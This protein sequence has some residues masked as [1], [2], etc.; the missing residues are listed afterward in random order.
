MYQRL[1]LAVL[2]G[3]LAFGAASAQEPDRVSAPIS[4]KNPIKRSD[5][6]TNH[7]KLTGVLVSSSN[8]SALVNGRPVQE[9]DHIAGA[10]VLEIEPRGI[11]VLVGARE[12]AINVGSSID[13]D[14]PATHVVRSTGALARQNRRQQRLV[15]GR[16]TMPR[17]LG[18][19]SD[20][21]LPQHAV[22]AGET[23]S[24]IALRYRQGG[25]SLNQ[26]MI[27]LYDANPAAFD[28][29]INVLHA[30]AVLRIPD[31]NALHRQAPAVATA[32]VARHAARWRQADQVP[33][34]VADVAPAREY[35]AVRRG[36]TLSEIASRVLLRGVTLDQM[37]IALY[38]ANPQAFSEN[39]NVLHEGAILR[40]P[41]ELESGQLTPDTA[42]AE[43]VRHSKLWR[44]ARGERPL[45]D[46]PDAKIM[47]SI[48]LP[49]D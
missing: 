1:W 16:S 4:G 25:I 20:E 27:A 46:L 40:I 38:I 9:G 39:I 44:T 31:T 5:S 21:A 22:Q 17:H 28:D 26:M 7:L 8:R 36:E 32:E 34:R 35:G 6:S 29:N 11:R 2:C 37:M 3:F 41:A 48:D 10:V 19:P 42:T 33:L 24:G 43:V 14:A 30:G 47:A 15:A 13:V 12:F 45:P 49:M 23:L 18:A